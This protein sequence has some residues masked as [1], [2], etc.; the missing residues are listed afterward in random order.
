MDE[1]SGSEKYVTVS[2]STSMGHSYSVATIEGRGEMIAITTSHV[3][4]ISMT[5][6]HGKTTGST[7]TEPPEDATKKE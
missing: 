7:P 4:S 5:R 1:P 3:R 6:G 2:R